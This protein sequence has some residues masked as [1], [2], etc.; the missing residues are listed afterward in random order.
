MDEWMQASTVG[1]ATVIML[2]GIPRLSS[3]C[4]V[5]ERRVRGGVRIIRAIWMTIIKWNF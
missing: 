1:S 4:L 3:P 2:D 5:K